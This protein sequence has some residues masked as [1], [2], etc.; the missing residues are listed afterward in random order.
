M[1]VGYI[2][3]GNMGGTLARRLL[4]ERSLL[5]HDRDAAA[6]QRLVALGATACA[7]PSDLAARCDTILLCLPT[8]AQVRD[9]IF[10][11]GGIAAAASAGTL[12]IDQTTGDPSATRAMAAELQAGRG[13]ELID[14]PVAGGLP[15]AE[16]GTIA[17]LVGATPAQYARALPVLQGI[18]PKVFHAGP[19]GTGDVAKLTNNLVFAAMRV[20][21]LEAVALAVKN[22]MEPS[23]IVD[24]LLAGSARNF[25]LEH[26]MRSHVLTGKLD[27]G[28]TLGLIHKDVRLAC[29]LGIEAGV[30]MLVGN[31][32]RELYQVF[33]SEMGR[34]AQV[35][36]A[37]VVIDRL[38]GTQV[39]PRGRDEG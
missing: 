8:S 9:V 33:I 2:G 22:G 10:G 32:V 26:Y 14:A 1:T 28:F 36:T 31:V 13:V 39:V 37:A 15:A 6:V 29:Q 24:I 25:F 18:S 17:I 20:A 23:K 35:N 11:E 34:D 5:V 12:I 27:S 30:P 38:A 16:A 3:L 7:S 19:V 21:T 4:R